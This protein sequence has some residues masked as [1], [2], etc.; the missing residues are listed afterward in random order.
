L[1]RGFGHPQRAAGRQIQRKARIDEAQR[2]LAPSVMAAPGRLPPSPQRGGDR[3][4]DRSRISGRVSDPVRI[5]SYGEMW[6][7]GGKTEMVVLLVSQR[8]S[9]PGAIR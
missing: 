9:Q 1:G 8:Y 7:Y 4:P 2:H 6:A 5:V 3:R